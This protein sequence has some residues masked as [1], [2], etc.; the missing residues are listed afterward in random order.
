MAYLSTPC[1]RL[2]ATFSRIAFASSWVMEVALAGDGELAFIFLRCRWLIDIDVTQCKIRFG[3]LL[4]PVPTLPLI[5]HADE[6]PAISIVRMLS[7]E[8]AVIGSPSSSAPG[9]SAT[10]FL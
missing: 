1:G 9:L 3:T 5:L 2:L 6:L 8:S 4:H 10:P 7:Y